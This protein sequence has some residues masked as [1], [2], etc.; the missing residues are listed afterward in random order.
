M[1]VRWESGSI[2]EGRPAMAG[3]GEAE[4]RAEAPGAA[5]LVQEFLNTT[6]IQDGRERFTSPNALR[7]WLVDAGLLPPGTGLLG[8]ADLAMT[9]ALRE[10]L[11][12]RLRVHSGLDAAAADLGGLAGVLERVPLR[13]RL[14]EGGTL[15]VQPAGPAGILHALGHVLAAVAAAEQEGTWSRLKACANDT[16]RW[17]FYDASRNHT[18]RWCSMRTCGSRA[19]NRRAYQ[20]RKRQAARADAP[21]DHGPEAPAPPD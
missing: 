19:K 4:G 6:D 18:S 2:Y 13:L 11:R 21:S 16:C 12:A 20:A 1:T 5:R 9:I 7:D 3:D 17:A 8:D 15:T 14:G 10:G